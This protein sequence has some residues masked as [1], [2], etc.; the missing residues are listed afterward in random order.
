MR[1]SEMPKVVEAGG[2]NS[3]SGLV[4]DAKER[5]E[6]DRRLRKVVHNFRK[7]RKLRAW[8]LKMHKWA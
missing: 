5:R 2:R 6:G 4:T 3:I 1:I 7:T 8:R